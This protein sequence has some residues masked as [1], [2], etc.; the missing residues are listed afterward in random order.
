MLQMPDLPE[1]GQ[2]AGIRAAFPLVVGRPLMLGIMAGMDQKDSYAA[3]GWP[4]SLPSTAEACSWLGFLVDAVRAVFPSLSA[5]PPAGGHSVKLYRRPRTLCGCLFTRP[6]LCNDR[7]PWFLILSSHSFFLAD[8]WPRSS[9]T[10]VA[11]SWL[12]C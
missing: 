2:Y 9:S 12:V 6:S 1:L 8:V 11:C 4:R 10:L 3:R 7:C 5:C